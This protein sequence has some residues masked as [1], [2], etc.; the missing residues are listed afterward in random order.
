M[1]KGQ[2]IKVLLYNCCVTRPD[3]ED[4]RCEPIAALGSIG[5]FRLLSCAL[6]IYHID[7]DKIEFI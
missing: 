2:T 1:F 3:T 5:F 7:I 4:V 6:Q